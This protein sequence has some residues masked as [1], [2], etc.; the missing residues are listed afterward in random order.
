MDVFWLS[1]DLF[2]VGAEHT[3]PVGNP[4]H[5]NSAQQSIGSFSSSVYQR[6]LH[7]WSDNG[8]DQAWNS[9]PATQVDAGCGR[10]GESI[11]KCRSVGNDFGKGCAAKGSNA[12]GVAQHLQ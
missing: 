7:L 9:S 6:Q 12:L 5:P 8:N 1:N 10:L 4:K 3:H 11:R 2:H